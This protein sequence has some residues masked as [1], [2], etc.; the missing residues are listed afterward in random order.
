MPAPSLSAAGD[1]SRRART[2]SAGGYAPTPAAPAAAPLWRWPLAYGL[3]AVVFL[4]MDAVWLSNAYQKVYQPGI[5]HLMAPTVDWVAGAIFYLLYIGGVVFFGQAPAL[6]QG[7]SLTALGRGALFGLMAYATY[8][9]T[10]QATLKDWPWAITLM[11]LVWGS[12][13]S[14]VAAWASTALTLATCRRVNRTS[15][16]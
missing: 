2:P 4:A 9:L 16:R 1:A 13:A 14:G 11:D 10:N 7:R 15:G 3:T 6:Q 8:D 5:G 12:F